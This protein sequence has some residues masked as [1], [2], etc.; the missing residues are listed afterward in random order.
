MIRAVPARMGGPLA[1]ARQSVRYAAVRRMGALSSGKQTDS[2]IAG[3][4][5]SVNAFVDHG[6]ARQLH[7]ANDKTLKCDCHLRYETL[8]VQ[9]L[10]WMTIQ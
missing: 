7:A 2:V 5:R 6:A 3:S 8:G 9:V 10:R 4:W 1:D